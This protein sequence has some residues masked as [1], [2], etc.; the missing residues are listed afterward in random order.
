MKKLTT[1]F[2]A[3]FFLCTITNAQRTGIVQGA[4]IDKATQEALIG[5]SLTVEGTN[6]LIGTT[7]DVD[8]KF[9]LK[10]PVGSY[11]IKAT[12]LGYKSVT[13]FNVVV[14]TGNANITNYDLD[15]EASSLTEVEIK[16]NR[17]I[18]VTTVESPNSIQRLS[19][20]EIKTSPG[21]NFD[22]FKVVQ[23]L[24]GVGNPPTIG[25]RNDIVVRGGAP[26]ENIY[27]LDGVEI[28]VINHFATQ[29]SSGG[30]NGILNV[31]FVEEL[32]LSSSAFDAKYD[33]ALSSVFQFKQ[34]DGNSERLQGN[35]RG[36]ISEAAATLEGPLGKNTT[37]LAS[38]RRSFLQYFFKAINLPIRPDY[39]DFQAKVTHKINPKTTLT[40]IGLGAIDNF[41]TEVSADDTSTTN[42]YILKSAP[43]IKQWNYTNG[44][45]LKRLLKNG[46]MN[47]ALSRNMADNTFSQYEDGLRNDVTKRY[48]NSISRE[49]ENKLRIDVNQYFGDWKISY[50]ASAQYVKYSNDFNRIALRELKSASGQIIQPEVKVNFSTAIG[51]ARYGAFG[52][53]SRRLMNDRLGISIGIR[54]DMNT[55][56]DDGKNPLPAFSPRASTSYTIN[57]QWKINAS[58]GQY[59]KLPAYTILGFKDNNNI[60]R[61]KDAKYIQSTHYVAGLEYIPRES[62]RF[63]LEGFYKTYNNYPTSVIDGISIANQGA[64]FGFIGNEDILSSGKG[65]AVGAEFF[66]QQ[67]LRKNFFM[68]FS[69][70]YVV[71]K[72]SGTDGKLIPSAWDNRLLF[73]TTI[74]RKFKGG[75]EM[76]LKYRFAGGTPYT[77]FDLEASRKQ[78][79]LTGRGILDKNRINTQRL[80]NFNQFDFRLDKKWNFKRTT[81]DIFLDVTNALV[82]K[83]PS[84]PEYVFERS[85]DG[86]GFK[87]SDGKAL[88]LD[89]S[90]A[91]PKILDEPS[92]FVNPSIGILFEF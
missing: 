83:N 81:F 53:L 6:P 82:L 67:K 16:E 51:F 87:T 65:N 47:I 12:Y 44:L 42:A 43:V 30:S 75:W 70:T 19:T 59:A 40:F 76:G 20:E 18:K 62:I 78:Y 85:A 56:T 37:F 38:T 45:A 5:V 7:T 90:N 31:S 74:G 24:P 9:Q 22:I 21:G 91:F 52:Q 92:T 86:K 1:L 34:R 49:I 15:V 63:T 4:V 84:L 26:G 35:I 36:S 79:A 33:N 13:K 66:F 58:I 73:S 61:N 39:W 32:T 64:D 27:F 88:L 57:K 2:I 48:S 46:F 29:G 68:V 60:F 80:G 72:F 50:G 41:Y 55:F 14:T 11:N 17:S 69:A 23:T 10:I 71:S 25:N 8:G 77:P 28:P 3:F 89:G 54:T